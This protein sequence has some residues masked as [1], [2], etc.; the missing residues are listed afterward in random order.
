MEISINSSLTSR[1]KRWDLLHSLWVGWT[2][3]LGFFSWAAFLYIGVRARQ[4]R[5]IVWGLL[6]SIPFVYELAARASTTFWPREWD[7]SW[8]GTVITLLYPVVMA[9]SIYHA[10]RVRK[11]YLV[12]LDSLIRSRARMF[13]TSKNK[14]WRLAHSLW[15]GWTFTF[16]FFSWLAFL[17]AGARARR[18]RWKLWGLVYAVPPTLF[19]L[20]PDYAVETGNSWRMNLLISVTVGM[21]LLSIIHALLIRREYLFRLEMVQ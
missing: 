15:I 6:Y 7:H 4:R 11:E 5:W 13:A 10:L 16:G 1:S 14:E 21:G 3:T 19:L 20:I 18:L 17:Y 8:E 2:F 9:L 12:R